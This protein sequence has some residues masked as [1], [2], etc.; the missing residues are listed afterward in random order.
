MRLTKKQEFAVKNGQ[1]VLLRKEGVDYVVMR[2]DLY[3][4]VATLFEIDNPRTQGQ[5]T[6]PEG[7]A[8]RAK[9]NGPAGKPSEPWTEEKNDRRCKLID[10]DI[11]GTISGSEKLELELR[12][13][14]CC[15]SIAAPTGTDW[16]QMGSPEHV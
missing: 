4:R 7:R 14:P 10:K 6:G 2:A 9:P 13:H 11:E 15:A 12:L 8:V 5:R 16:M 1:R 3:D